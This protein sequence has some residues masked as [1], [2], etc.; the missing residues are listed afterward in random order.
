MAR[1]TQKSIEQN[2]LLLPSLALS[3][4]ALVLVGVL[5]TG[6]SAQKT[7]STKV[8]A[9]KSRLLTKGSSFEDL[10]ADLSLLSVDDIDT[11]LNIL[12]DQE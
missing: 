4:L 11:E 7:T 5:M 3:A 8:S 12:E 1:K 2:E 6:M 9:S 10:Q